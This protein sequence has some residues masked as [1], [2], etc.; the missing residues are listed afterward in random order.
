MTSGAFLSYCI[1]DGHNTAVCEDTVCSEVDGLEVLVEYQDF[2]GIA[3][4]LLMRNFK[5]YIFSSFKHG[6]MFDFAL[7]GEHVQGDK[8]CFQTVF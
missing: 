4:F 3:I 1:Y 5:T 8:Q 2:V 7:K 6:I